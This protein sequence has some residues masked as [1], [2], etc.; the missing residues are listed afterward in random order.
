MEKR[1]ILAVVLMIATVFIVNVMFP[2]PPP[3]E[4][5]VVVEDSVT[6]PEDVA[7]AVAETLAPGRQPIATEQAEEQLPGITAADEPE[8]EDTV[9]VTGPLYRIGFGQH[10]GRVV[11]AEMLQFESLAPNTKGE[12]VEL[13]PAFAETFFTH[14]WLVGNDT[15][16]FARVPFEISPRNGLRLAEGGQPRTLTLSYR[17]EGVPF[18]LE[19]RYTFRPDSYVIDLE[20]ELGG[21]QPTGWWAMGLGPGLQSNEW[22]PENDYDANLAFSGKGPEGVSSEKVVDVVDGSR[23]IIDGPFDWTAVRTKYFVNALVLPPGATEDRRFGGVVIDGQPNP[24]RANG[25]ASFSV[26]RDGRFAYTIYLG[27]QDYGRLKAVGYDLEQVTP[28]GYKWLQPVLRPLAGAI[29]TLLVWMHRF[30]GLGYGWILI[31]FGIGI[32]VVLFPLYQKSMRSQ[33]ATMRVQPL[34]KEIQEKYKNDP[35]KL[36]QEMMKLYREHKVNPLGGC[37]PMLLPFPILI[38]LF[39]VFRDTIEF[40]GVPFLWLPDLSQP[41]PLYIIPVLM[42]ASIWLL[43]WITHT[44]MPQRNPQ[45][46]MMMWIMPIMMVVL[47]LRF[48][49]GLNLY[50]ATMNLA[51]LPQQLYL[52]KERRA[53]ANQPPPGKTAK[54]KT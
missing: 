6:V 11:S 46:K 8:A 15:L 13:V 1:L 14:K 50:Y 18:Q 20:G 39:F 30:L 9:W 48:A 38:A 32:R 12:V 42:G 2:P 40:R 23:V 29:T 37:L 35:Q 22:D 53:A 28:Y 52:A 49:S 31:I 25:F 36:Q 4:R 26:P 34:M 16:D 41:D 21:V 3:P 17:P 5:P 10:G 7:D 33:M 45:M 24:F 51:S 19:I 47:F 43:Q 44:S 27:P 54:A